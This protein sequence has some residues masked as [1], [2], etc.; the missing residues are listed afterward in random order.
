MNLP[1]A[2]LNTSWRHEAKTKEIIQQQRKHRLK[3]V[4]QLE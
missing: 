1:K 4:Q 3:K 2:K